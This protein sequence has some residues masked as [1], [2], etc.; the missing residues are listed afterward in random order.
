MAKKCSKISWNAWLRSRVSL[1][2]NSIIIVPFLTCYRIANY[3]V[4]DRKQ[5]AVDYIKK[6]V[7]DKKVRSLLPNLES[8]L[9]DILLGPRHG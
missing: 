1:F 6:I 4:E 7:G 8:I 3:T 2:I 9:I 5:I